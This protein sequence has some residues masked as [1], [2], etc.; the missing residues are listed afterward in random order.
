MKSRIPSWN[1]IK[2]HLSSL[3]SKNTDYY[4]QKIEEDLNFNYP[5][6]VKPL[7]IIDLYTDLEKEHPDSSTDLYDFFD[8]ND[9]EEFKIDRFRLVH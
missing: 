4:E 2:N 3:I 5:N 7:L 1:G 9:L 6:N 8:N